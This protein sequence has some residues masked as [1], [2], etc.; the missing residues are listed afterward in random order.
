VSLKSL[1]WSYGGFTR[2]AWPPS[3]LTLLS[4]LKEEGVKAQLS[5]NCFRN[6]IK[7]FEGV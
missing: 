4:V 5:M 1:R 6:Q 7:T 2:Q 3:I